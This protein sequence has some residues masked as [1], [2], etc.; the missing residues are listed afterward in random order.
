[1]HEGC[2]PDDG[3]VKFI[4]RSDVMYNRTP[5]ICNSDDDR[6]AFEMYMEAREAEG[7]GRL[8]EAVALFRCCTLFIPMSAWI[9][10]GCVL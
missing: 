5:A 1:M 7:A 4:I 6:R 9:L 10:V 2:P 3:H 8:D